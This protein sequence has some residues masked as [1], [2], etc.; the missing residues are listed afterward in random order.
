MTVVL[1]TLHILTG[2]STDGVGSATRSSEVAAGGTGHVELACRQPCSVRS[3]HRLSRIIG[4]L[5][6]RLRVTVSNTC[7]QITLY[8]RSAGWSDRH[9]GWTI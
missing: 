7:Q 4:P 9:R 5:V 8:I 6:T 2:V 1:S 3:G